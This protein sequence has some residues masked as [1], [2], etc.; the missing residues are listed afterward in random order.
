MD[1]AQLEGAVDA[2]ISASTST[3]EVNA[4]SQMVTAQRRW[5][6]ENN[7]V[8][9]ISSDA[10][11]KYDREEQQMIRNVK[12]WEKDPHYFKVSRNLIRICIFF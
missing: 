3:G 8:E 5:F 12:P 11:F 10:I 6:L 2:A 9:E 7:I 1:D 4:T